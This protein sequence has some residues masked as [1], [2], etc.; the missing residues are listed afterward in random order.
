MTGWRRSA[1][2]GLPL[3]AT[4]GKADELPKIALADDS[5][6]TYTGGLCLKCTGI[7]VQ[8]CSKFS[9]KAADDAYNALLLFSPVFFKLTH[10]VS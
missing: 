7:D 4:Q 8:Y 1:P 6:S 3:T 5:S 10:Q 9:E 2:S